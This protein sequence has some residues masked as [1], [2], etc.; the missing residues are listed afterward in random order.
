MRPLGCCTLVPSSRTTVIA[1][2]S[3]VFKTMVS[4]V[5]VVIS[6]LTLTLSCASTEV[7][8]TKKTANIPTTI[9]KALLRIHRSPFNR[10]SLNEPD[11]NHSLLTFRLKFL[12]AMEAR[13]LS[14]VTGRVSGPV[15]ANTSASRTRVGEYRSKQ[16]ALG[17]C[18]PLP[19]TPKRQ[20][21]AAALLATV[22]PAGSVARFAKK[23]RPRSG[24]GSRNNQGHLVS[25]RPD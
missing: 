5:R 14:E 6:P 19:Q 3:V 22:P 1:L 2:P 4:P 13:E 10:K 7:N 23:D 11:I 8:T 18:L 24:P 15:N 25:S 17:P 9:R 16:V 21:L 20:A 12:Q